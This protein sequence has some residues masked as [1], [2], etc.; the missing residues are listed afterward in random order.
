MLEPNMND[1]DQRAQI[2]VKFMFKHGDS[3]MKFF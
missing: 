1:H 3:L 2:L